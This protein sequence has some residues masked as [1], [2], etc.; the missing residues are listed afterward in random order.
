MAAD[1]AS[2][3]FWH[4]IDGRTSR[5]EEGVSEGLVVAANSNKHNIRAS[6]GNPEDLNYLPRVNSLD[7]AWEQWSKSK[8]LVVPMWS[9]QAGLAY[10]RGRK[11]SVQS[12]DYDRHLPLIF[13]R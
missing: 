1:W 3:Q 2:P 4:D 6:F 5:I 12:D 7:Q 13:C 11:K 10:Q 8:Y 9:E